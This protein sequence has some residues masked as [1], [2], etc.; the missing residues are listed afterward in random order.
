MAK[1]I[2]RYTIVSELG[3]GGMGVV[4]KAWEE[5]LQRHV[6]I[7][8][9]ADQYAEDE[10]VVARF[11]REARA[12]ADVHHANIVQVFCVDTHDGQP[13]FVMEYVEGESLGDCIE[14]ENKLHPRKAVS[15]LKEAASGLAA[16]HARGVV[17][18]DIKP[19]NLMLSRHGNV[20]VVDFGI[21][22]VEGPETKLTATGMAM[23][24]PAYL[25]PEVCLAKSVD[26]RSDIFSLG[27]VLYEMLT[28][29]TPFNADSPLALMSKVVEARIPDL[30][31]LDGEID[32]ALYA[33]L[34]VMLAPEPH[35]RYADCHQLMA[36]LDDYL[37]GQTPR[38]AG[39][40]G[41]GP[42]ED[43]P[44]EAT[45]AMATPAVGQ[46]QKPHSAPV[47]TGQKRS[48][49]GLILAAVAGVLIL[50]G[51]SAASWW[52]LTQSS[53]SLPG[54]SQRG[55]DAP[56]TIEEVAVSLGTTERPAEISAVKSETEAT[57]DVENGAG[58]GVEPIADTSVP[59]DQP[60]TATASDDVTPLAEEAAQQTAG[61]AWS[62][63]DKQA[64]TD[65]VAQNQ[66]QSQDQGQQGR[67][68][69]AADASV[70]GER[71]ASTNNTSPVETTLGDMAEQ[72]SRTPAPS[73]STSQTLAEEPASQ[74]GN[75]PQTQPERRAPA[76]DP[77]DP[78]VA[79]VVV[80]DRLGAP[81][82][83][84][85]VE[86]SLDHAGFR[87]FDADLVEAPQRGSMAG[88]AR[89]LRDGG[90]DVLVFVELEAAGQS[91]LSYYGRNET[92]TLANVTLRV[93]QLHDNKVMGPRWQQPMRY[94][95]LNAEQ[96]AYEMGGAIAQA[97]LR[98]L[99]RLP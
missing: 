59:T 88:F 60:L 36:D 97:T 75:V 68:A 70:P 69:D 62:A 40:A 87:L 46:L 26:Q 89:A 9:L 51:A 39:K 20:K 61:T 86:Q 90:A 13:Y 53:F 14:R 4:Y 18:R 95:Q 28:G 21:A 35:N 81:A 56:G 79:V 54:F 24:T 23:G 94:T 6:A 7:K 37:A 78:R 84:G 63:S 3:R 76:W 71:L 45:M 11:M 67:G 31:E 22:R 58:S 83:Q 32:P 38:H 80:G 27:V 12:V 44:E 50:G 29:E 10:S 41:T 48:G 25:S 52:A 91:Q 33:I 72:N 64:V 2:G 99:G 8:M 19:A 49:K 74:P 82:I 93:V 66:G 34:K 5:S 55:D 98:Q 85:R 30:L 17:H 77:A 16:A 73:S 92:L 15:M 1:Q 43:V 65:A 96:Q 42:A 47:N 57:M